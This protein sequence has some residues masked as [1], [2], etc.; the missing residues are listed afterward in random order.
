MFAGAACG[1]RSIFHPKGASIL[2]K[3]LPVSPYLPPPTSST[4]PVT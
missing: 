2:N 4:A 3:M 1:L